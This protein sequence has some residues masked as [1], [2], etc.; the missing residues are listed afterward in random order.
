M[1]RHSRPKPRRALPAER[2][3]SSDGK[4]GVETGRDWKGHLERGDT[5]LCHRKW[6]KSREVRNSIF[7]TQNFGNT[8]ICEN[9]KFHLADGMACPGLNRIKSPHPHNK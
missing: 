3:A 6:N 2:S 1:P 9:F 4:Q 7:A 8:Q 5:A